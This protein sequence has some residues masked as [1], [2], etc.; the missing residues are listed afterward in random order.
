[1]PSSISVERSGLR[2]RLPSVLNTTPVTSPLSPGR[3]RRG[4]VKNCTASVVPGCTPEAPYAV[5]RRS[6]LS[7]VG[8]REERLVGDDPRRRELRVEDRLEVGAER[9]VAVGADGAG[10]EQSVAE[11]EVLLDEAAERAALGRRLV[12][13]SVRRLRDWSCRPAEERARRAVAVEDVAVVLHAGGRLRLDDVGQP[14]R[15]GRRRR[16]RV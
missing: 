14:L 7:E 4:R 9:A 2:S 8:L 3:D 11:R 5:R 13:R 16:R 10:D 6:W 15:R 1:M 12:G